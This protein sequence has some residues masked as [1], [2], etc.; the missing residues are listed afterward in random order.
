MALSYETYTSDGSTPNFVV[1]FDY[2]TKAHIFVK[3][4]NVTAPFTWVSASVINVTAG[5]TNGDVIEVRRTTPQTPLFSSSDGSVLTNSNLQTLGKQ[6]IFLTQEN[7]DLADETLEAAEA[8]VEA[9]EEAI[10]TTTDGVA[11]VEAAE[12]SALA[13]LAVSRAAGL[14]ALD[15]ADDAG[16]AAAAAAAVSA[17]AS[18]AS[19]VTSAASAT[20][21]LGTSTTSNTIGTGSKSF[22]TQ[23]GKQF[24]TG[25]YITATD[26]ADVNNL[27]WGT[28]T[29]YNSGTGALVILVEAITGS[30]TKTAWNISLSGA[31]GTG[32]SSIVTATGGIFV[33]SNTITTDYTVATGFNAVSAGPITIGSGVSVTVEPGSNW[34]IL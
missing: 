9:A 31:R 27:M 3:K 33:N 5:V 22:T 29:S 26:Q 16:I 8:A 28:V 24:A 1:P 7:Q 17:A 6:A 34:V 10:A 25:Q 19:A 30:G 15:A 11:A 13:A 4:N 14:A 18:A 12:A 32:T 2:I 23:T 20:T 21:I